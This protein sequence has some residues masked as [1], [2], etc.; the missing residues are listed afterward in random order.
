MQSIA[1]PLYLLGQ[2]VF[3]ALRNQGISQALSNNVDCLIFSDDTSGVSDDFQ[4]NCKEVD[5]GCCPGQ[6]QI[7]SQLGSKIFTEAHS[8]QSLNVKNRLTG[9]ISFWEQM[10]ASPWVLKI[11]REG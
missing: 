3:P 5:S 1:R 4:V 6:G 2:T 9:N 7:A 10:G 8:H 11:L